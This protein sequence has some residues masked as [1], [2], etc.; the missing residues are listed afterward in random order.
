MWR[1][2]HQSSRL[3]QHPV[4][5]TSEVPWW[6]WGSCASLCEVDHTLIKKHI[7]RD[8]NFC[9][10]RISNTLNVF[11]QKDACRKQHAHRFVCFPFQFNGRKYDSLSLSLFFWTFIPTMHKILPVI[12]LI[13]VCMQVVFPAPLG[14]RAIMPCRTLW[15]SN[16][17]ITF[18]FQG[19]WLIRPASS[20]WQS[21]LYVIYSTSAIYHTKHLSIYTKLW[22][23]IIFWLAGGCQL[24]PVKCTPMEL[25]NNAVIQK[26]HILLYF[27]LSIFPAL[28]ATYLG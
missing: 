23:K 9:K 19:G 26:A 2:S 28:F 12:A 24:I 1:R 22:M 5:Q 11:K 6:I 8:I 7:A 21:T 13:S 27:L 10:G 14:P 20:T 16:S 3:W 18:S 25:L 17:W 4:D 15:V